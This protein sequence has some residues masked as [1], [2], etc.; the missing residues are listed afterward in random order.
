METREVQE[1]Y[2][3]GTGGVQGGTGGG[4][5]GDRDTDLLEAT[6]LSEGVSGVASSNSISLIGP[7]FCSVP[8]GCASAGWVGVHVGYGEV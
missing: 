4:K 6:P 2:R 1:G 8:A 7:A 3:G 5:E